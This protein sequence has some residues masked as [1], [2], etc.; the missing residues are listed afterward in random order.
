[1]GSPDDTRDANCI[2]ASWFLSLQV[3]RVGD[4]HD[5]DDHD[6]HDHDKKLDDVDH[7]EP[8]ASK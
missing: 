8:V 4:P 3:G 5:K 2:P 7:D 1:M 6:H